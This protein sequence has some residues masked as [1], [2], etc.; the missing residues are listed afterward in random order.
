MLTASKAVAGLGRRDQVAYRTDAADARHERRHL[1]E[2]AA[3]AEFLEAAKLRDVEASIF[4]SAIVVE[5]KRDLGMA[6]DAGDRIDHNRI[7][8]LHD[9]S[10]FSAVDVQLSTSNV[11]FSP[12]LLALALAFELLSAIAVSPETSSDDADLSSK[13]RPRAQLRL[14]AFEQFAQHVINRVGRRWAARNKDIHGHDFVDGTRCGEQC[15]A[16]PDPGIPGSKVTF[17]R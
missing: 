17:S 10:L 6:L 15:W 2:G 9:V 16:P 5:V 4:D 11:A 7:A 13:T 3:F 12:P 8:L 14:P 1:G